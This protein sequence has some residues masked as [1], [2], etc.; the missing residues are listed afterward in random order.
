MVEKAEEQE[1]SFLICKNECA[2]SSP[3]IPPVSV[4]PLNMPTDTESV[5][6]MD[7]VKQDWF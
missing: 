7:L 3:S 2:V 4:L 6:K 5:Q 1:E